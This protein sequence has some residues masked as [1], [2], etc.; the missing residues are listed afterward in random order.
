MKRSNIKYYVGIILLFA[1]DCLHNIFFQNNDKYD[2]YLFYDHQRYLTNILYDIS[3]LFK[4]S[5]LTYFL[6]NL[7]RRIFTPLFITSIFIWV[8]YFTFYN[9]KTSALIIPIYVALS[10]LYNTKLIKNGRGSKI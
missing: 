2:V 8:S 7:N 6:I 10:I 4:F 3:H 9:Q 5:V 1:V